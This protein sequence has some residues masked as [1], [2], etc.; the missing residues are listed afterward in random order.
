M[1][2][3]ISNA[4][5]DHYAD[6]NIADE[7]PTKHVRAQSLLGPTAANAIPQSTSY[8]TLGVAP[9]GVAQQSP[10]SPRQETPLRNG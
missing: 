2:I 5:A 7:N 4:D 10:V 9:A 3:S 6:D 1:S 8:S